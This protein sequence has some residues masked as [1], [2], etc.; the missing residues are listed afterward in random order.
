[1][2]HQA[3]I[4]H[5]SVPQKSSAVAGVFSAVLTPVREVVTEEVQRQL[6]TLVHSEEASLRHNFLYMIMWAR[7]VRFPR[8]QQ[9]LVK[10][11]PV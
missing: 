11:R 9:F 10:G 8:D 6:F 3:R 1:M 4:L 2:E 5:E 7:C